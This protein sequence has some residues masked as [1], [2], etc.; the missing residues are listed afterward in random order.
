MGENLTGQILTYEY[1]MPA[2]LR[3]YRAL[4]AVLEQQRQLYNPS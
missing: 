3:Q 1:Q 4:E 2:T